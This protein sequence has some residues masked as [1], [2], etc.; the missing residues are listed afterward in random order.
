MLYAENDFVDNNLS[1]ADQPFLSI[2]GTMSAGNQIRLSRSG[3]SRTRLDVTL[4][5]RIAQGTIISPGAPPPV[6]SQRSITLDSAWFI[7]PGSWRSQSKL[8]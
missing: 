2:Y 6:G 4:D 7:K 1:T 5:K 8:Q 3:G